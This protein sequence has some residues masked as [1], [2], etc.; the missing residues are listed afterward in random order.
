MMQPLDTGLAL[1]GQGQW[2]RMTLGADFRIL[3][4][5]EQLVPRDGAPRLDQLLAQ[6]SRERLL[7]LAGSAPGA[8][9]GGTFHG[10]D[11]TP[12][13]FVLVS[14][15]EGFSVFYRDLAGRLDVMERLALFYRHFHTTPTGLC[16]TD[17]EGAIQEANRSFL[18]LYGY[19]P[20][21]VVGQN[22]RILKSGRQSPEAYQQMWEGISD[23]AR[24]NW[25]GEIVNRKKS[26]EEV[27]VHLTVSA[28]HDGTG[29]HRGYIASTV[30]LTGRRLLERELVAQNR[31]L[32]E[33][34]RLKGD[35][36]AIT[37]HDLKSPLNAMVSR[38]RLLSE[39]SEQITPEKRE[40]QTQ[41]IIEAGGKMA[42]FIDELLDLDKMEAGLYRLESGRLHLD[43][44]LASCIE[45]NL[46]GARRRGVGI[47]L[48]LDGAAAPLRGDL[49]KLEQLFNNLISN[50]VKFSPDGAAIRVCYRER[51]GEAKLVT[52]EDEGPGIP[53]EELPHIFD[54][55]Y[56]VK[57]RGSLPKR[58]HGAGLGLSIVSHVAALH[59]G[60]VRAANRPEGGCSFQVS[61]PA[62]VPAQSGRDLAALI[63]DPH[64]EISG[65]LE[66]P[67]RRKGV[68]CYFARNFHEVG[69]I[70]ERERPELVF[71]TTG[72]R[73]DELSAYLGSR[74]GGVLRVGIGK[75]EG[76][77][78]HAP[79]DCLLVPPVLD[80]EIY[81]L[82]EALLRAEAGDGA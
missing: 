40:E 6:E 66:G 70:G 12:W 24:A 68:S 8:G 75:G 4:G 45:T 25:S 69:R 46:P 34:N 67:L 11:G 32:Q 38:A 18:E 16:I 31:E 76:E 36:M 78:A 14:L 47:T 20:E 1:L 41:K 82:L 81:Q 26:G 48:S 44:L 53:E 71:A 80:L 62:R 23:P 51:P 65:A 57:Q 22:P 79:F 72:A 52:V 63:V 54:R 21:E 37:S 43:T 29:K 74:D 15:G 3:S 77:V 19:R 64:G 42:A 2:H 5:G 35:L 56:Q 55:Y 9:D 49:M 30:D 59:G 60:A 28:V 58:V 33:L 13:E 27:E 61:L 39:L 10:V 73:D 7:R 50:A 17:P